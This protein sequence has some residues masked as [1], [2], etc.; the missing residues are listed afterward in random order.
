MP[1][2]FQH[3][4]LCFSQENAGGTLCDGQVSTVVNHSTAV[5][6]CETQ[7]TLPSAADT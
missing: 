6:T 2:K 7:T 5:D 3:T 1:A 4:K